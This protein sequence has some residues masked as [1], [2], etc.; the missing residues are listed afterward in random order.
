MKATKTWNICIYRYMYLYTYIY[1]Q[2][3]QDQRLYDV[4][5]IKSHSYC[6]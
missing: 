5:L 1:D 6:F 4:N 2:S 3:L